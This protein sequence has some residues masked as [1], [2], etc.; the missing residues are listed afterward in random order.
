M[1]QYQKDVLYYINN[2]PKNKTIVIKSPRQV[3]KSSL[4]EIL[5]IYFSLKEKD[6]VSIAISPIAAQA[7]KLYKDTV[8]IAKQLI[9]SE[10]AS[11]L[12]VEFINGSIVKFFSAESGDN[13][14]GHNVKGSGLVV[15][16]EAAYIKDDFYWSVVVP[17][18][19]VSHNDII[20][21]ST[22]KYTQGLFY[23]LYMQGLNEENT[24]TFDW[25]NYDLS[26]YLTPDLLNKYSKEMPK[27]AFQSEYLGQFISGGS[28]LFTNLKECVGEPY[29][30]NQ[31]ELII[32][33]DWSAGVGADD[34]AIILGQL[35]NNK[36]NIKECITF[37]DKTPNQTIDYI[38]NII[39]DYSDYKDITLIVEKNSIG[40]IYYKLLAEKLDE[41]QDLYNSG[42]SYNNELNLNIISFNTTN[43]SKKR[44]IEQLIT[45]FQNLQI[46]IT[47]NKKLI[48]ELTTYE[49]QVKDSGLIT[50][51]AQ[52]GYHDDLVMSLAF[53][54]DYCWSYL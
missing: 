3:G 51:N 33:I 6:S 46:V 21:A 47:D 30:N 12:E 52:S 26:K 31:N 27:L 17:F 7:R 50:Y 36:I 37:N 11:L 29:F 1:E 28:V 13:L 25:T 20:I 24:K 15:V 2:N 5:L 48:S 14:R 32:G 40:S 9:K 49:C 19:N 23:N 35:L 54:V 34:T 43:S 39:K 10:N 18:V 41:Y 42:V 22:P 16:D 4:L 8:K 38:L 44:I 45:V 53:I